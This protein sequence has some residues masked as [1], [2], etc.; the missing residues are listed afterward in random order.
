MAAALFLKKTKLPVVVCLNKSDNLRQS[1]SA[2]DEYARLPFATL[3]PCSA[4]SGG[5]TAE[6]LDAVFALLAQS[7]N[8]ASLTTAETPTSIITALI[9]QPNVGKSTLF[10]S[11]TGEDRVIVNPLPHTTRDPNDTMLSYRDQLITIIDTAGLRRQNRVGHGT[12]KLIERFSIRASQEQIRRADVVLL[13]IEAHRSVNHQDK[14]LI[15][16]LQ[17]HGKSFIIVVNKWDLIPNKTPATINQFIRYYRAQFSC[18]DY[19]PMAFI[20]A[21]EQQRVISLLDLVI[22]VQQWKQTYVEPEQLNGVLRQLLFKQPKERQPG[23]QTKL[24]RLLQLHSLQQVGVAP[25]R[26][27]LATPRPKNVAPALLNQLE[28]LIRTVAPF[29]GVPINIDVVQKAKL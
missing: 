19:V 15:D 1:H 22:E 9:G 8:A 18:A 28:K 7:A 11:L 23:R 17:A 6:L 20:S 16:Y 21:L 24:K 5:G 3:I 4:K 2:Q 25:V 29:T 10:N 14:T 26:F 12:P 27:A 13:L